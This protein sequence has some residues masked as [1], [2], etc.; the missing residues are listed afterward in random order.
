[1]TRLLLH[2]L[3]TLGSGMAARHLDEMHPNKPVERRHCARNDN[4][5]W[6]A[7]ADWH[8]TS[9]SVVLLPQGPDSVT[10]TTANG[11]EY[12][13]RYALVT[14]SLGVLKNGSIAFE[15]PLPEAKA[16]AIRDMGA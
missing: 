6:R 4:F 15:P 9:R 5:A 14:Q 1:M 11:T 2:V 3:I 16:A 13:A 8:H 7:P 10:V 12:T